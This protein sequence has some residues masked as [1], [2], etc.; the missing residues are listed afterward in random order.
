GGARPG[1]GPSRWCGSAA[2]GRR[3]RDRGRRTRVVPAAWH[4]AGGPGTRGI[5]A[6]VPGA[7]GL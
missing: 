6:L 2:A 5:G 3:P 7:V 1:G 4:H